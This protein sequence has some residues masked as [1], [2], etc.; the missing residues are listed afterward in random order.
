MFMYKLPW[1]R[2]KK[3]FTAE[4]KIDKNTRLI[5]VFYNRVLS[6]L[7]SAGGQLLYKFKNVDSD[8]LD[9]K[10]RVKGWLIRTISIG[11]LKKHLQS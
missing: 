5:F 3:I 6:S 11:F 9:G 7:Y 2:R 4:A 10:S 8:I 1:H